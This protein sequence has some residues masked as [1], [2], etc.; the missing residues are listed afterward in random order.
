MSNQTLQKP[1]T[2]RQARTKAAS[3]ATGPRKQTAR[4]EGRRD[5]TP[6]IFGWGTHLTRAQKSHYRAL[7]AYIGTGI[8]VLA[9]IFVFVFGWIQQSFIIPNA[10]IV[11]ANGVKITQD[12]YRKQ[13]A[14]EA[15]ASFNNIEAEAKQYSQ[16]ADKVASGDATATSQQQGLATQIQADEG[17]YTQASLA[18][19]VISDLVENVLIQQGMKA[20]YPQD[21]A[22]IQPTA[23]AINDALATFK[24][25]FPT[26]QTYG[27][28]LSQD[29]LT[30]AD[31]RAAITVKL[32]RDLMQSYLAGLLVS[33]T[34]QVHLR[35]IQTNTAADA[36][37]ALTALQ[38]DGSDASWSTLAKQ[39]SLD[40]DSKNSG[41]DKGWF[42]RFEASSDAAIELWA[43]DSSRKVGDL[44][45]VI[46]DAAG[47]YDVVQLL[48]ID[49]SRVVDATALGQ[50]KSGALA[51]WISGE[52][53]APPT[54]ISAAD[55]DMMSAGR[56]LPS[57]PDLNAK[58]PSVQ[59]QSVPGQANG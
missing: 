17:N 50:A 21:V 49:P 18:P 41:G 26:G 14:Y 40:A 44:S 29:N 7:I 19:T 10:T 1:T 35:L 28:F 8:V 22:K 42:F 36:K 6:F 27:Q 9:I 30:D 20:Q 34:K 55:Q 47:T 57:V 37:K 43:F 15:A 53:H 46:A 23:K 24:S 52:R 25:S 59:T 48:G 12:T 32:R 31:V 58:L 13:L 56:N 38:K 5:N 2:K 33:P 39:D 4:L 11:T 16:L 54:R 3:R 45:G 51:H